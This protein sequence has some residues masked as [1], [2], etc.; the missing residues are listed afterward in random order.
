MLVEITVAVSVSVTITGAK[1]VE[2]TVEY[3][4]IVGGSAWMEEIWFLRS[5]EF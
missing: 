1:E 3:I 2:V 4:V 5:L